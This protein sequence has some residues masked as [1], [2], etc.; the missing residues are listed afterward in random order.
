MYK[1]SSKTGI[2]LKTALN[3]SIVNLLTVMFSAEDSANHLVENYFHS[4]YSLS[5]TNYWQLRSHK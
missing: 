3:Q 4:D 5:F 2:E 1:S